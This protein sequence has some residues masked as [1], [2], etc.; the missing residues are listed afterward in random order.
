MSGLTS[1]VPITPN[2]IPQAVQTLKPSY[3]DLINSAILRHWDGEKAT[4]NWDNIGI[5]NEDRNGKV[6]SQ[7]M[8][9]FGQFNISYY[10]TPLWFCLSHPDY[11]TFSIPPLVSDGTRSTSTVSNY[12][13]N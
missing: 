12:K 7:I 8:V 4:C 5:P 2:D 13:D 9:A 3:V 11:F 6:V 10:S 1:G